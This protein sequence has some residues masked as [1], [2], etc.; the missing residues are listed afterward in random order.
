MPRLNLEKLL[1]ETPN[2]SIQAIKDALGTVFPYVVIERR[3]ELLFNF[4]INC[5]DD[6]LRLR[7]VIRYGWSES[8]NKWYF[9]AMPATPYR[10]GKC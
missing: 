4:Q 3:N 2:I 5:L 6:S 8:K 10:S 1:H 9:E 7:L